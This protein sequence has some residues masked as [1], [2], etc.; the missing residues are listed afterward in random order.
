MARVDF[1]DEVTGGDSQAE[2]SDNRLNVSARSDSRIYYNARDE[3]QCYTLVFDHPSAAAG[4]YSAYLKNTSTDK[5]LVVSHVGLNA[6]D[7]AKFK[8]WFV[9]GTAANGV[10]NIPANTNK[11]SVQ[12]HGIE[13]AV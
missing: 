12:V 11:V 8:L 10:A 9:T 1:K 5:T 2:G 13:R 7:L 3:G 6:D 4:Q